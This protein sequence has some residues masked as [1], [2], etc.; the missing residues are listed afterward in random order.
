MR[1][2]ARRFLVAIS[3]LVLLAPAGA[4]AKAVVS[5]ALRGIASGEA[6]PPA[7]VTREIPGLG[8]CLDL[9]LQ[10]DVDETALTDLGVRINSRL[11]D[12]TLT[13]HVPMDRFQEVAALSGMRRISAAYKTQ[14][15]LDVS[16]P[17]TL[18]SPNYWSSV[19]PDFSGQAG[20]D[21][22]LGDVDSGID[23]SH[24]DFKKADGT[25]RIL[26][27]WD[28]N[29]LTTPHPSGYTYG[30]EW[31]AADINA[32]LPAK[33]S[34]GHG[35]HVMGIAA[36]DG[37]ATG[38]GQPA[39]RYIG[40][41]PKADII[42]VAT[43][44][45]T[46]S[47]VDGVN[48]IFQKAA[49]LGKNA[50]VNLSLGSQFG[51]H[52]GTEVFD[53]SIDALTGAGKIV[54]VA[55]GNDG[56]QAL[57]ALQIV[58]LGGNQTVTFSVPSYTANGGTQNDF[59]VI[60]AY[61]PGAANMSVSITSPRGTS[62]LGPVTRGN[63][64]QKT[65]TT[66]TDGAVYIENGYTASPSGDNN[67]Y[68]QIWDYASTRYPR[69]GTWTITLAPVS[70]TNP[71][72]D[73]WLATFQL[74]S[75]Y[76]QPSFTSD[77]DEHDTVASPGSAASAITVGAFTSR[78]KWQ[79]I[80]GSTYYFTDSTT[81]GSLASWSGVGPLRNGA[82]K[83]DITAPGTAIISA[84]S[85][86][87]SSVPQELVVADGVHW[88]MAGTSMASP[89]VAGGVALILADTPG[90]NPAQVKTKLYTDA[91]VDGWTGSV[92]NDQWGYGKLRMLRADA[93]APT[94]TVL[95]PNG[96]ENWGIGSAQDITWTATDNVAVTSI[97]IDYS[98]DNGA[99]WLP[100]ATG[101][102]NDGIYAWTVPNTPTALALVRVTASDA[103]A[104]Q[105]ADQSD[106]VFTIADLAG[107]SV[108]VTAPNGG[109]TW[110]M[111]TAQNITWIATDDLG[112]TAI[113][114]EF[115]SDD[116]ANWLPVASGETN[117][118][119]YVWTVPNTAS[120]NALVKIVAH[121]AATNT[122]FD[123]CDSTFTIA[124]QTAPVVAVTAANGG[125]E[126]SAG[127]S[128]DITWT[129]SDNVDV[130]SIT[131]EYS[132]DNGTNWLPV[133]SGEANDGTYAWLVPAPATTE[134]LVRVT[135]LDAAGNPGSDA[136]D[137]VFTISPSVDVAGLP[138]VTATLLTPPA[139]NPFNPTTT[140]RYSL[141]ESGRVQLVIY[142]AQGRRVRALVDAFQEG[143]RWYQPRWDG[144]DDGGRRAAGGT[145]F[146]VLRTAGK[147]WTHRLVMVK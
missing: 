98:T 143:G 66:A 57:H 94:V 80:N 145:Y 14:H 63:F 5:P 2:P 112:V 68:I 64:S 81:V 75:A 38:N 107:P 51:A 116:G 18:A 65:G 13:V 50:V 44:Y 25:T 42:M 62:N 102:A 74:G 147:E 17:Q 28:Q 3:L 55:A 7:T 122:S 70:G 111:G 43:D 113:D 105:T 106:A 52:D 97:D 127:T 48:Y 90:L 85:T 34:D 117:D 78:T 30:R 135:A 45:S 60:D 54:V 82:Q 132:T 115:S 109:E 21:V 141:L 126:W 124:D 104:N 22:I 77:V 72:L 93:I 24:A 79:S 67:I 35:T 118:S 146:A 144:R 4:L 84:L 27:I 95:A 6:P 119:L 71:Q 8:T 120:T 99:S 32:G 140:L 100:V 40:M 29:D 10:G 86:T 129:A 142:D 23:W 53:T 89:H 1:H 96:G 101:E 56:G 137:A 121:D 131:I 88:V 47:V 37:S 16:T 108:T 26:Y 87:A 61:Y 46:T 76:A 36:G 69:L 92:P 130:T 59:V 103:A 83:P 58:P 114:I 9:F 33:D 39:N 20:A 15:Y 128:H 91:L 136:S 41:A 133:A 134:A 11:D 110:G 49:A 139:P 125:E 73:L 138:P 12:G 19:P 123:L 31:T